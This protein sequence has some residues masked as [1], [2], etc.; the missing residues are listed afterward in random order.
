MQFPAPTVAGESLRTIQEDGTV[1]FIQLLSKPDQL[2]PSREAGR[3]LLMV[4]RCH[5]SRR[6]G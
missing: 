1:V 5:V 3:L 6:C 4:V 2:D